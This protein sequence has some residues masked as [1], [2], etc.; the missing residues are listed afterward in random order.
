MG[1]PPPEHRRLTARAH[2]MGPRVRYD[3]IGGRPADAAAPATTVGPNASVRPARTRGVPPT[4][5]PYLMIGVVV[6]VVSVAGFAVVEMLHVPV[7]SDPSTVLDGRRAMVAAALGAALLV[8]DVVAPVPS[9][10]VMV[11]HG[12]LFGA[13]LGTALSLTGRIGATAAGAA[14]GRAGR[15]RAD[16][17][18][19]QRRRAEELVGRWGPVAV[20]LSRPVPVLAETVSVVAGAAHMPWPRLLGA[21]ALGALPEAILYGLAGSMAASFG[22][23]S[24]VFVA[25]VPLA[26]VTW[27]VLARLDRLSRQEG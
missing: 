21:A 11:A 20:V 22:S 27:V 5:R 17:D 19:S 15:R 6:A 25:I 2:H 3:A 18:E 8:T 4:A 13:G 16:P 26:L 24:L 23:A 9:S 10:L 7:L 1:S 12:A 14:L